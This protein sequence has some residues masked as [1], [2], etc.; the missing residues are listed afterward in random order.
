MLT[1]EESRALQARGITRAF[2][3]GGAILR[4]GEDPTRVLVLTEGR[5]KTVI[6]TDDGKEV[7]LGFLG[8]GEL[9]GE[10]ATIENKPRS[11]TVIALEP[12]QA[13]ALATTD[14]W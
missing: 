14:F 2:K 1:A 12:V 13:L 6:F 3:R 10:V 9:I 8:P 5:A 7:V 11:A 4:E